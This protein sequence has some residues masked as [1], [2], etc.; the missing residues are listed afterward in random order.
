MIDQILFDQHSRNC[1]VDEEISIS[2]FHTEHLEKHNR[3]DTYNDF[4]FTKVLIDAL[5]LIPITTR[6][7]QDLYNRY[8]REHQSNRAELQQIG[9]FESKYAAKDAIRWFVDNSFLVKKLTETLQVQNLDS[10]FPFRFFIHDIFEQVDK[11]KYQSTIDVYRSQLM[12]KDHL[13]KFKESLQ[14]FISINSFLWALHNRTVAMS[15]LRKTSTTEDTERI[16]FE[17]HADGSQEGIKPF[18]CIKSNINNGPEEFLFP[19]GSI[20]RLT[21]VRLTEGNIWIIQMTLSTDADPL[22]QPLMN[23]IH[24]QF[25]DSTTSPYSFGLVLQWR[26]M[27]DEARKFYQCLSKAYAEYPQRVQECDQAIDQIF[28]DQEN[29]NQPL[30]FIHDTI[31][32]I[33]K[34]TKTAVY[35]QAL[36]YILEGQEH[37]E[38]SELKPAL[39]CYGRALQIFVESNNRDDPQAGRCLKHIALVYHEEEEYTKALDYYEKAKIHLEKNLGYHPDLSAIC[40]NI[41][42]VHKH[43]THYDQAIENYQKAVDVAERNSLP[44]WE[45]LINIRKKLAS[46]YELKKDFS[47]ALAQYQKIALLL[48]AVHVDPHEVNQNIQRLRAQ[49]Q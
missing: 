36:N 7:K 38:N 43:L 20:F 49:T 41:G 30:N 16:L 9:I 40:I 27:Y 33:P 26:H 15:I 44:Q 12:R 14:Q 45:L 4:I 29:Y 2:I 22:L 3:I 35:H 31:T 19:I 47:N 5:L 10:L 37:Q 39:D 42:D 24:E 48:P 18:S 13:Q 1:K 11:Y 23:D 8:K 25:G 28:I 17:I 34:K 32:G 21:D 46:V 6:E